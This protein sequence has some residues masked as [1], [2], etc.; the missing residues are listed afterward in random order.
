MM[1][2]IRELA[3]AIEN[4]SGIQELQHHHGCPQWVDVKTVDIRRP[5]SDY[6]VTPKP[7]EY[8]LYQNIASGCIT[9]CVRGGENPTQSNIL[10]VRYQQIVA[11]KA[12]WLTEWLP[13]PGD[14]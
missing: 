4:G 13:L 7:P 8:R 2:L 5:L 10:S 9:V 12:R 1:S 6:R 3:D 11:R 14:A